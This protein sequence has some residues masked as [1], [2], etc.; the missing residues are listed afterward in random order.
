MSLRLAGDFDQ[1]LVPF[2][3]AIE[4]ALF[5]LHQKV[6][7]PVRPHK[8]S[9]WLAHH[10]AGEGLLV[11]LQ[12]LCHRAFPLL[13]FG[14]LWDQAHHDHIARHT[15]QHVFAAEIDILVAAG[16]GRLSLLRFRTGKAEFF[17]DRN[18]PRLH[19]LLSVG[20]GH[21]VAPPPDFPGLFHLRQQLH[22]VLVLVTLDLCLRLQRVYLQRL[23]LLPVQD[24][25]NSRFQILPRKSCRHTKRLS[26]FFPSSCHSPFPLFLIISLCHSPS[27]QNPHFAQKN[28]RPLTSGRKN[29]VEIY[30]FVELW[31][32]IPHRRGGQLRK[33]V[34][35]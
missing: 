16:D 35:V 31:Y 15:A 17:I 18:N 12:H 29:F 32:N 9:V 27:K 10:N 13:P 5:H 2:F 21:R 24:V 30:K 4:T 28:N 34:I 6:D 19:K 1:H 20:Q 22:I 8:I 14:P 3:G 25:Q 26:A 23:S 11:G 33:E 7:Q